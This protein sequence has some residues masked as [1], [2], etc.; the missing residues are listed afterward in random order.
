MG[1][2]RVWIRPPTRPRADG[3]AGAGE[4]AGGDEAGCAGAEDQDVGGIIGHAAK[5][6]GGEVVWGGGKMKDEK[7][8]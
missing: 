8:K 4:V 5:V 3:E 6:G 7:M 1:S 2:W